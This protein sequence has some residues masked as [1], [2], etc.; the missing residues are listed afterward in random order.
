MHKAGSEG[1][2]KI[3]FARLAISATQEIEIRESLLEASLGNIH[4]EM[5][6]EKQT[7]RKRARCMAHVLDCLPSKH[8]ILCSIPSTKKKRDFSG[9]MITK[10]SRSGYTYI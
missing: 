7:K 2:E 3:L 8:K 9:Q 10:H 5:R 4:P 1:M 6:S